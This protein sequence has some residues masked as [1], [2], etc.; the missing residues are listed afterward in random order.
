MA[1][2]LHL[3]RAEVLIRRAVASKDHAERTE[4]IEQAVF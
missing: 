3:Q 1:P 4:L 2:N